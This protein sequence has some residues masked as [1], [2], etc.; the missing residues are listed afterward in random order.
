MKYCPLCKG[1][2]YIKSDR[3]K[4]FLR[5][6]IEKLN[7]KGLSIREIAKLLKKGST[8]IHWHIKKIRKE[9]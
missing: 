3:E 7:K 9:N 4:V 5:R 8:T 2:G 6:K 1:T